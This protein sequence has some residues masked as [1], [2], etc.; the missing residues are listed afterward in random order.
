MEELCTTQ[1]QTDAMVEVYEHS[2]ESSLKVSFCTLQELDDY[3]RSRF[4][5]ILLKDESDDASRKLDVM[6]EVHGQVVL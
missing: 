2:G 4:R 3:L 6:S 5:G 1:G